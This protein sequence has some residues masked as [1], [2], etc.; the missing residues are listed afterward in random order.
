MANFKKR[1]LNIVATT[2]KYISLERLD[3]YDGK[4]KKV[5]SDSDATTLASSKEYSDSLAKNYDAIGSAKA[6]Q[7]K[8]DEEVTRA[9]AAEDSNKIL[10]ETAQATANANKSYIGTIPEDATATNIVG[11]IQEKTSG[12]VTSEDL[13][14]LTNRVTSAETDIDNIQKDYLKSAD[15][16]E[17][18]DA[19]S[20]EATTARAAEKAN[21]DAIDVVKDDVSTN[22]NAIATL[23]GNSSVE[24]SVDKKIAVA[25]NEFATQISDDDTV[26]TYKELINYAA[27]HG[28]E[29]TELV[30]E[31]D[32]NTKA[33]ATLNGNT[34]TAG[35]V[36][37]KIADAIAAQNLGQYATDTELSTLSGKVTT[38]EGK[39]TTLEG[40]VSTAQSDIDTLESDIATKVGDKTVAEQISTAIE[41][42]LDITDTE[43]HQI[44]DSG[45]I[46]MAVNAISGINVSGYKS[47]KV[48]IKCVNTADNPS[49]TGG[50]IVFASEDGQDYVFANILGN[51][52]RNTASTSGGAASFKVLDTHL[53][54]ECSSRALSVTNMLSDEEGAGADNLTVVG[55]GCYLKCTKPIATMM[56]TNANQSDTHFYGVGSRVIVW[57]CKI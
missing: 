1:R 56:V 39:V 52:I 6:V 41:P 28:A 14:E 55:G 40:K 24:G 34:S 48:A 30:G 12:V 27:T 23:N 26:N 13:D 8:L 47:L 50:A 42:K 36:D 10:T 37:K 54:C 49:S 17:L 18:S 35:S 51:L 33:I 7:D 53:V 38:V 29:F 45:I 15:K 11:Y 22:E 46:T 43:W 57:G 31:V 16:T 2:K 9:K 5:I 20:V 44:Y 19:I 25:I 4:I 32:N 21:A 3:L